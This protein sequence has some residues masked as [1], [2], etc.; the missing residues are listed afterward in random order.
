MQMKSQKTFEVPVLALY[1]TSEK[2]KYFQKTNIDET[3]V[4]D[5]QLS[6]ISWNNI[7]S[8]DTRDRTIEN[9]K[10]IDVDQSLTTSL[11]AAYDQAR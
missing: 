9:F 7:W 2:W 5:T 3:K 11:K 6:H 10:P 4:Q 1:T 8:N